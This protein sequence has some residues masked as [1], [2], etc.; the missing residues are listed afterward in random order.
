MLKTAIA[1]LAS[2][3]VL[4][5][6]LPVHTPTPTSEGEAG[7]GITKC[8]GFL[9]DNKTVDTK[10]PNRKAP[11]KASPTPRP[12]G[13]LTHR[14]TIAPPLSVPLC[15]DNNSAYRCRLPESNQTPAKTKKHKNAKTP[16]PAQLREVVAQ[17]KLPDATPRFGPDPSVNEWKMLAVGFPIW[18]WTDRPT[19][20]ATTA[21]NDGL[22]FTLTATWTSTTFTMGDGQTKSCSA[23]S[24][25]PKTVEPAT[26]PSPTC[27]YVYQTRSKPGHP[28][29]VTAA[30]HWRI[31]WTTNGY[32]GSFVH[33][34]TGSRTLEIGE[35]QSLING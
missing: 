26:T 22:N 31:D 7:C 33:T 1:A 8:H 13:K 29:T 10:K 34:Y 14:T 5:N 20:L 19:H 28:Y 18:L 15:E 21:H 17:L 11:K 30:T 12:A 2:S 25:R 9:I 4:A 6:A 24:I 32:R 3:M 16:T 35:L 23:T 27:G